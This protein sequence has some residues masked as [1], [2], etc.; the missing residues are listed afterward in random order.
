MSVQVGSEA[1]DFELASHRGG[2]LRLSDFR[3]KQRVLLA[4]HPLAWT[5]VCAKQVSAYQTDRGRFETYEMHILV[6]S[7]DSVPCKTAWAESLGGVDF[8]LLSDFHPAGEVARRYGV[9]RDTGI[10]ER[11]LFLI[12]RNGRIAFARVHDIPEQPDNADIFRVLEQL[13]DE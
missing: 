4:F 6:I 11:A 9:F 3:G 13:Q 1:P 8:D 12:D 2:Q 10:S 5:P 7:V